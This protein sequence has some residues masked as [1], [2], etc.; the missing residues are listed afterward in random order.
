MSHEFAGA[1][2]Y[3]RVSTPQRAK[4]GLSPDQQTRD[5]LHSSGP[6][7]WDK[8]TPEDQGKR[9]PRQARGRH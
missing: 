2:G 1:A 6:Q 7:R 9:F 3:V 8:R 5:A 4:E